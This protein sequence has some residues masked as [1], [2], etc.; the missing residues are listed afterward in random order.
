MNL[1]IAI[2]LASLIVAVLAFSPPAV[3]AEPTISIDS[4][5][6][7]VNTNVSV[8]I[9][10]LNAGV[11]AGGSA[12]IVYNSSIVSVKAVTPGDF[13][14]RTSNVDNANG[15]VHV[16]ASSVT[17]VGLDEAVLVN[18]LFEGVSGGYTALNIQNASLNLED[19]NTTTPETAD[20][21]ITVLSNNNNST[22]LTPTPTPSSN[23]E[24]DAGAT[25]ESG[26]GS[27][28]PDGHDYADSAT[29]GETET[30]SLASSNANEVNAP[31]SI[32]IGSFTTY[33]NS[34]VTVPVELL[35]ANDV[36]GGSAKITFNPSIVI[37][38]EVLHGDF[39][40]PISNINNSAGFVYIACASPTA[41]GKETAELAGITFEGLSEGISSLDI[42]DAALN[43]EHGN[44]ITPERTSNG[45]INVA[46]R[47]PQLPAADSTTTII[48]LFVFSA[49]VITLLYLIGKYKFKKKS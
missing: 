17:A 49:I 43:D 44:L 31:L 40:T 4:Y 42:Q 46:A 34:N 23:T 12:K 9:K 15:S 10:V 19:G 39:G 20:G 30:I 38:K 32:T 24:T 18:V 8:P 26:S 13:G 28:P 45:E 47:T 14:T 37:A 21:S 2:V 33:V 35:N 41:V 5:T 48:A 36:A 29:T 25:T 16:A 7:D 22:A 6:A 27:G 3:A 11:F 1:R